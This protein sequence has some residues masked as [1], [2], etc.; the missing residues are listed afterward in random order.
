MIICL[1][2]NVG[3][4]VEVGQSQTSPNPSSKK[5]LTKN[6]TQLDS[7]ITFIVTLSTNYISVYNISVI[8]LTKMNGLVNGGMNEW[9]NEWMSE[10][11]NE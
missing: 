6:T 5:H 9:T 10:S 3:G 2:D 8:N 7:I 11:M 4:F 1:T